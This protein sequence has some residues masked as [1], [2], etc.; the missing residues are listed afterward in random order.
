MPFII[1]P[2]VAMLELRQRLDGE[3][4]ENTTYW[5]NTAPWTGASL[6]VLANLG[7]DWWV[8]QLAPNLSNGLTLVEGFASD[9]GS[10]TGAVASYSVGLP[11]PG[12]VFNESLPNNV[13]AC[14]SI[15]TAKRGR[16]NRGRNYIAGIPENQ[17]SQNTLAAPFL[18]AL[19]SAYDGL[20][21]DGTA[22]GF[23]MQVVSRF[24]GSSIV[25]GKKKP[26]PRLFGL[27]EPVTGFSFTDS[28]VDSLRTR[29]PNH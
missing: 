28:T 13:A 6:L 18:A 3:E 25:D 27:A 19:V 29:L 26:T 22:A 11:A 2:N 15:R 21:A 10:A 16:A 8:D 24:E 12:S 7:V 5:E 4:I 23:T 1:V 17:V 14:I 9:Q 20:L